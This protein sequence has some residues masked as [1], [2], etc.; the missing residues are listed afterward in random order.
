MTNINLTPEKKVTRRALFAFGVAS[1][2]KKGWKVSR[3]PRGGKASLRLITR[4][5]ETHKVSIR[6]SQDA[7]IAFPPKTGKTGWVTLD[8]VDFVV[9]VSVDDKHNPTEA[10]VHMIPADKARDRFNRAYDARKAANHALPD[11]RGLW[12]SL[13][14]KEVSDPVSYVGA[15]LGLDYPAFAS[16]SL[17]SDGLPQGYEG[18]NDDVS[19]EEEDQ[20]PAVTPDASLTISEAKRRLAESFGVPESSIK[21]TI[22][23]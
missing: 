8:D 21:I 12:L 6:T 4:G 2:E 18:M 15:G 13:Y 11:G 20:S 7:S 23:H 9:A 14:E 5:E 19:D 17:T 16:T 1:L 10:R 3:V 22:E